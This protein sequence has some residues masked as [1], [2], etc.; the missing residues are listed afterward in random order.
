MP[1]TQA[2]FERILAKVKGNATIVAD[3]A[4]DLEAQGWRVWLKTIWP[5]GFAAEFAPFHCEFWDK[6]WDVCVSIKR[7]KTIPPERLNYLL[8]WGR[9]LAKSSTGTP[10][11]L[12][13]AALANGTYS[14]YLSATIP[15][16][17]SHL[18]NVRHFLTHPDSRLTEFYPHLTIDPAKATKMGFKAKDTESI[19]MT[20]G[21]SIF[22][23]ISIDSAARGFIVGGRRPDDFNV[24]DIDNMHDSLMVSRKKLEHLTRSI[25][26][27]RD[28]S[29]NLPVT[30]KIL[31]NIITE[32]GVVNQIHTGK[33][34]A[35]AQR[36]TIGVVNTFEHLN[37]E[38]YVD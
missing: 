35:F 4:A 25:L 36:T 37:M 27:T 24:D 13:K 29:S 15:Q 28:I 9:A 30:T 16:A 2:E 22:R 3:P 12:M 23:A 6:W 17:A 21:G 14:I 38:S 34:D 31:Q 8:L 1:I 19:F 18:A 7:G 10:A 20:E 32:T 5:F 11:T 26:L 33:S